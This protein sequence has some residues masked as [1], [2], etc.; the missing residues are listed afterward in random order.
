[1]EGGVAGFRLVVKP[2]VQN[3]FAGLYVYF[4]N[5]GLTAEQITLSNQLFE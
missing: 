5:L 3:R 4:F 1:M 2:G